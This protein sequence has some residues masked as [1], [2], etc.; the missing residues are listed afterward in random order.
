M[1]TQE[2]QVVGNLSHFQLNSKTHK[3]SASTD[4]AV[5][6]D[7]EIRLSRRFRYLMMKGIFK[8]TLTKDHSQRL[9]RITKF[10]YLLYYLYLVRC[11][12]L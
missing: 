1:I 5:A 2:A 9:A 6:A 12:Y 7:D 10:L 3:H 4:V 8:W 11:N